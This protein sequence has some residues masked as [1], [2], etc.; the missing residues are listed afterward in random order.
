[1]KEIDFEDQAR[2]ADEK[3]RNDLFVGENGIR[4]KGW[5]P[6]GERTEDQAPVVEENESSFTSG[7]GTEQG[8]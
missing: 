4:W 5:K 6:K 8:E 7:S 3:A 1:M 2:R